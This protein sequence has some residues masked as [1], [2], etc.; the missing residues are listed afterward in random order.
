MREKDDIVC[1]CAEVTYDE[2]LNAIHNGANTVEKIGDATEA[3]IACGGCIDDLEAI[4][5]EELK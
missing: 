4:L 1:H 3:G 2:I 5:E